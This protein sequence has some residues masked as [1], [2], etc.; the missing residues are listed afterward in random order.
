[1]EAP[2]GEALSYVPD[3]DGGKYQGW[4][5]R[6]SGEPYSSYIPV[7]EDMELYNAKWE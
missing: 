4:V 5:Y 2:D 6:L 1:M 3:Y 7:Y